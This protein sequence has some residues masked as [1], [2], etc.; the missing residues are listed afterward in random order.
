MI[1]HVLIL[2][3]QYA[4]SVC[5]DIELHYQAQFIAAWQTLVTQANPMYKFHIQLP[6]I[7][8]IM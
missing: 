7:R 1:I 4:W 6:N 5:C 2:Y 8:H 3:G